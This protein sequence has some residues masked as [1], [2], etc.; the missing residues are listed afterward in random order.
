MVE[1]V[2]E[3]K[4]SQEVICRNSPRKKG[5]GYWK[6]HPQ[7]KKVVKRLFVGTVPKKREE[8]IG[9]NSPKKISEE[10]I[11]RYSPTKKK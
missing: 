8:V 11:G 9:N 7:E 1:T 5:R 10:V 4:S 2:P 6:E 3:N